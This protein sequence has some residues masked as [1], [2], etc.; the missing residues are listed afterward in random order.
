MRR[1]LVNFI[2]TTRKSVD[3]CEYVVGHSYGRFSMTK[4]KFYEWLN[5]MQRHSWFY[6]DQGYGVVNEVSNITNTMNRN[7]TALWTNRKKSHKTKACN[8]M[9]PNSPPPK[10]KENE[11]IQCFRAKWKSSLLTSVWHT[12]LW[13]LW[14]KSPSRSACVM[15]NSAIEA[16]NAQ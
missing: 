14:L 1:K 9:L 2:E 16:H 15:V 11:N 8:A 7:G 4:C 10:K 13:I 12:M 3:S 6:L 5:G